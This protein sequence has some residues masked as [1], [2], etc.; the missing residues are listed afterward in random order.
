MSLLPSLAYVGIKS[1]AAESVLAGS[2][3]VEFLSLSFVEKKRK[4]EPT[5]LVPTGSGVFVVTDSV[6]VDSVN[7]KWVKKSRGSH[8]CMK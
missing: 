8:F 3:K 5:E 6:K 1:S 4:I 2:I 7:K